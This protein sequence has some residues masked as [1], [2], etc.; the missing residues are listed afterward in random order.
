MKNVDFMKYLASVSILGFL[1]VTLDAFFEINLNPWVSGLIFV[2]IGTGL[3]L[4]GSMWAV[5]RFSDGLNSTEIAH[6]LTTVVGILAIIMGILL[7]P[8]QFLSNINLPAF[9]GIRGTIAL[10]CIVLISVEAFFVKR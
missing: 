9:D 3:T 2:I 8:I 5:V 7:L 10:F 6:I 1:V 4:A